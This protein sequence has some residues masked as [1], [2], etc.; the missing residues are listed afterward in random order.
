M[1]KA[2]ADRLAEA[3]AEYLHEAVR[4]EYWGYVPDEDVPDLMARCRAFLFP[5]EE[6]FGI[7]PIQAMAAGRPVIAYAAGGALD[8]VVPGTGVLFSEQSVPA[9]MSAVRDFNPD[10]CDC[11]FVRNHARRFDRSVF[12][13]QL[14]RFLAEAQVPGTS[15]VPGT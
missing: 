12:R 7:A 1:L 9:I 15:K 6:D 2:L 3:L 10:D 13:S 14:L 4:K 5:G 11:A 8:T